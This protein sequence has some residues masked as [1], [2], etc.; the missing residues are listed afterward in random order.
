VYQASQVCDRSLQMLGC[1][2]NPRTFF[3]TAPNRSAQNG[4]TASSARAGPFRVPY[5]AIAARIPSRVIAKRS[6]REGAVVRR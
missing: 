6:A 4:C 2:R 3:P 5:A 1:S